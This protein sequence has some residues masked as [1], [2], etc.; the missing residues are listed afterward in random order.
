MAH[1]LLPYTTRFRWSALK[2]RCRRRLLGG[3]VLLAAA[4]AYAWFA[5][6]HMASRGADD[7]AFDQ[8]LVRMA[9][10]MNPP[11]AHLRAYAPQD[12]RELY[13]AAVISDQQDM[14]NGLTVLALRLILAATAGGCGLILL[15]AGS[16]EWEIRSEDGPGA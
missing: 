16:T 8:P 2:G 13:L 3:L 7:H 9:A 10:R 12:E 11:P 1:D 14:I 6:A 4:A 15:T 5:G